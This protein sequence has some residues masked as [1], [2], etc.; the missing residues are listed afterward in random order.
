MYNFVKYRVY[1]IILITNSDGIKTPSF[2]LS[3][4]TRTFFL[5]EKRID[6]SVSDLERNEDFKYELYRVSNTY[7]SYNL[8]LT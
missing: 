2:K 6:K 7:T 4:F 3:L 5:W 1:S 8:R